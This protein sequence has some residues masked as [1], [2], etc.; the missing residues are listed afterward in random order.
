ME[1]RDWG[2]IQEIYENA[3]LLSGDERAAFVA[4]KCKDDP[5]TENE[6]HALLHADESSGDF[7][8]SPAFEKGLK[9]ISGADDEIVGTT[10]DGRYLVLGVLA[11]G[12][13]GKLYLARDSNLHD[14]LVA[15][16]AISQAFLPEPEARR[17]F[18]LEVQALTKIGQHPNI[19]TVHNTG[20]LPDGRPYVVME[21]VD[22]VTLRSLIPRKGM[23]IER[24][25]YILKDI[26]T[27]LGYIHN[28]GILHR[29]LKPENIMIQVLSDGT[30]LV[31]IVDF[32]IAKV[33]DSLLG[34]TVQ[35]VRIGTP[36]YMSPEQ[37]RGEQ[38]TTASDV[39][40]MAILA[41]EMITGQR[42]PDRSSLNSRSGL[43][44]RVQ[45]LIVRG[46]SPN[47]AD[48][49]QSAKQYGDDLHGALLRRWDMPKVLAVVGAALIVTLLSYGIYRS[50][51][52][53]SSSSVSRKGFDYSLMVQPMHDGK[54]DGPLRKSNGD[55]TFDSGDKFQLNVSSS[56]SGFLYI[57]NEGAPGS[58]DG[59]QLLYPKPTINGG[60]ATFG[61]NQTF[62]SDWITFS[63]PPGAEN[64]WI[65]WST[66]QVGELESA[67][68]EALKNPQARLTGASLTAVKEF[69]KTIKD[70]VNAK[71]M[72]FKARS[73]A[74]VRANS[75]LVPTLVQIE[76]R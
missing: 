22:G 53:P 16:K 54:E 74:T 70:K 49:P 14:R 18:N 41:S 44:R 73:E 24:A 11:E 55:E 75:D 56:F 65:V 1:H 40:A 58:G 27:A 6:V 31:K 43:P 13:M 28:K 32:G 59:F 12:G 3:L 21:Y 50:I 63:G 48:R 66:Q 33:Q 25:A 10:V 29:D 37:V 52:Q 19:V 47:P 38:V 71:T 35:D 9:I 60:S 39:Y 42:P 61:A 17:R 2:R 64:L 7:L 30:E 62:A 34:S 20:E 5:T 57:F 26:G 72:R 15:I 23:E 45:P 68:N 46:L 36:A 76:H 51:H 69:L 4:S 67:K 8:E